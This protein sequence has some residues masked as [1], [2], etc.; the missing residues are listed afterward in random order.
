MRTTRMWGRT[1]LAVLVAAGLGTGGLRA[2]AT[3]PGSDEPERLARAQ[4]LVKQAEEATKDRDSFGT[5][6]RLYREAAD[7]RGTHPD[8]VKPLILAGTLS[9]Y[10]GREGQAIDDLARAGELALAFGDVVTAADSFLDA[11]WVAERDG[12]DA[13]AI[14]LGRR[15]EMLSSSPL[16]QRRERAS[17]LNR[18]AQIPQ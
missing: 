8:A 9:Y 2:Q 14:E 1:A 17:I 18:L 13:R 7:L 6:A 16:I 11:A 12:R 5:A 10:T 4:E 3:A 15:A